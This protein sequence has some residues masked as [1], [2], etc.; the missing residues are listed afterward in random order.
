[1]VMG[2]YVTGCVDQLKQLLSH[3][4]DV[5]NKQIME[6]YPGP[7]L[8]GNK[9]GNLPGSQATEPHKVKLWLVDFGFRS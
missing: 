4:P 6:T 5:G 1:M 7:V 8:G 3:G 2:I 9:Q